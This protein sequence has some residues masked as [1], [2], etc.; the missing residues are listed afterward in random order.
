M[1]AD[2]SVVYNCWFAVLGSSK[3]ANTSVNMPKSS[4]PMLS[5]LIFY[6][7]RQSLA[8]TRPRCDSILHL[9]GAWLF[10]AALARVRFHNCHKTVPEQGRYSDSTTVTKLFLNKV[11]TPIPQLSQNCSWTR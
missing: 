2:K 11:G 10:D 1:S 5:S 6:E 8:P 3:S 4:T 7:P 9:F